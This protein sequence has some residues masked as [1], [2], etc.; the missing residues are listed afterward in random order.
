[1]NEQAR[2]IWRTLEFRAPAMLQA[3]SRL[4]DEQI[5][6]QPPNGANT[7]RWL[8]WHIA[9]VEDNWIRDVVYGEARRY[10][11]G[12]SVREATTNGQPGKAELLEY[13]RE[14]RALSLARLE[15]ATDSDLKRE[16]RDRDFGRLDVSGV[17]IGVATS[18]AWHG[19]QL[20]LL[21]NRLIPQA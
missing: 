8:L 6:W 12:M 5:G 9:E 4:S 1:M 3:F 2:I 20:V 16:V 10:P 17:W 7:A 18:C 13:F 14:V 11:F 19:G 21:A 15:R